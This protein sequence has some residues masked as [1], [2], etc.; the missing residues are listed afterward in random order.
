MKIV[1][2]KISDLIAAEYNPRQLTEK[3]H[4]HLTD[5]LKRLGMRYQDIVW[6]CAEC[7]KEFTA[8]KTCKTRIPV[9][10]SRKCAGVRL[11]KNKT[12]QHCGKT[13]YNYA[14]ALYCSMKCSAGA[15]TGKRLSDKHRRALS[16]AKAGKPIKHFEERKDEIRAKIS[17]SLKRYWATV[18]RPPIKPNEHVTHWARLRDELIEKAGGC[19]RCGKRNNL[20][21]H[22]IV[23]YAIAGKHKT[24]NLVVL[25]ASCH[26]RTEAQNKHI[27]TMLNDWD[28]TALAYKLAM[29]DAGKG[30]YYEMA[31]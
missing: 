3:Q 10:C 30:V 14:N 29:E 9:Y 4:Q 13:F 1:T 17:A 18:E 15:K 2:R 6:T 5:S 21:V 28:I 24:S 31:N 7:G 8:R 25:C 20:H 23:P 16:I 11:R 12:C 22:H 27:N 19:Q 26:R